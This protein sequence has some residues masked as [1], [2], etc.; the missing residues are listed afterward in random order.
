MSSDYIFGTDQEE[1]QRLGFQHRVWQE[2]AINVWKRAGIKLGDKVLDIGS[3][4]GFASLDL[5]YLVGGK[6]EITAVELSGVYTQYLEHINNPI[7]NIKVLNE[8]ADRVELDKNY[9]DHAYSRWLLNWVEDPEAILKIIYDSLKPGGKIILQEYSNWESLYLEPES[10]KFQKIYEAAR[11]GW[12]KDK[13]NVKLG[14]KLPKMLTDLG[15]K[16]LEINPLNKIGRPGSQIWSWISTFLE[17]Y[18][19][20]LVDRGLLDQ[21]HYKEFHVYRKELE[22]TDHAFYYAPSMI[23][24]IAEK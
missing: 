2:E 16:I 20:K 8:S 12:Q 3:G 6:G 1:L 23:E 17:I 18:G 13:S 19:Q 10:E 14:M 5:S 22:K 11:R 7:H 9:F 24:I 21:K 15:F 4:P